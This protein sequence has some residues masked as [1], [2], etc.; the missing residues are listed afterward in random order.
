MEDTTI[1][2]DGESSITN[3]RILFRLIRRQEQLS[4]V[5]SFVPRYITI[6]PDFLLRVEQ[7]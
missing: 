5:I 7:M 3:S 6:T 2:V 4:L 1:F